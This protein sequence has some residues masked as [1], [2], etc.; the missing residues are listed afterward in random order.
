MARTPWGKVYFKDLHPGRLHEE[1]G[2]R[3]AFAYDPTYVGAQ[4]PAMAHTLPVR[5][6]P[7]LTERGLH[8]FFDNLVAEGWFRNAQARVLAV[9]ARRI[10]I[11]NDLCSAGSGARNGHYVKAGSGAVERPRSFRGGTPGPDKSQ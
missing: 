10:G 7:H 2:G 3:C 6:E 11:L 1:P 4:P 8:P 9:D 5:P